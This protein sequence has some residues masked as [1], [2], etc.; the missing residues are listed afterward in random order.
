MK[1]KSDNSENLEKPDSSDDRQEVVKRLNE[2]EDGFKDDTVNAAF[3]TTKSLILVNGAAVIAML[4]FVSS[5]AGIK[6]PLDLS[7][8]FDPM[9]FFALGVV[10][11]VVSGAISYLSHY[12]NYKMADEFRAWYSL[13]SGE[14]SRNLKIMV[15][16]SRTLGFLYVAIC[17]GSITLFT[18]GIFA[19]RPALEIFSA[20]ETGS[21]QEAPA[22]QVDPMTEEVSMEEHPALRAEPS[23]PEASEPQ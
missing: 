16:G 4:A 2:M 1:D 6:P 7:K 10:F 19:L 12:L 13:G 21:V 18:L 23:T 5:V 20:P 11:A 14:M 17:A 15:R 8:L 9:F 22:M 3:N